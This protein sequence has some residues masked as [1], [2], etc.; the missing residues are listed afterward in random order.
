MHEITEGSLIFSNQ[1]LIYFLSKEGKRFKLNLNMIQRH[2][3][4][5]DLLNMSDWFQCPTKGALYV[6]TH[7]KIFSTSA[8]FE[9]QK[10]PLRYRSFLHKLLIFKNRGSYI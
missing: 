9:Y 2:A 5:R 3:K 8:A 7:F 10:K 1:P 4:E 6:A